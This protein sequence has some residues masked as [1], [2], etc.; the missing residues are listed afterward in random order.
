MPDAEDGAATSRQHGPAHR[1]GH[2]SSAGATTTERDEP[3]RDELDRDEADNYAVLGVARDATP[4]ELRHAYHRL[5]K[6]WHPDRFMAAPPAL[7]ERAER[8]TRALNAAYAVLGDLDRRAAYDLRLP[9]PG[10]PHY[11][12]AH[13]HPTPSPPA[14]SELGVR[15]VYHNGRATTEPA[16]DGSGIFLGALVGVIALVL[17]LT[18]LKQQPI[19]TGG[20]LTLGLGFI[21]AG[22]AFWCATQQNILVRLANQVLA[23]TPPARPGHASSHASSHAPSHAPSGPGHV[24]QP[25]HPHGAESEHAAHEERAGHLP[26]EGHEQHEAP[27]T[28]ASAPAAAPPAAIDPDD[29]DDAAFEQLVA[30][31]L[32]SIPDQFKTY[33][34]NVAVR[35]KRSPSAQEIARLSLREHGLLLGLYEGVDVTRQGAAGAPQPEVITI[36]RRPI[37][38]YCR[39][40]PDRIREQV[41]RTVLHE[42]AH[43]FGI[44]HDAMPDW[45]R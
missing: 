11:P 43:H 12:P 29:E 8:R 10:A 30:E 23:G 6:L 24:H 27:H 13:S 7:R 36:Y 16:D 15:D 28:P 41:R 38:R 4:D 14:P 35:V 40:D 17:I 19:G 20:Y 2:D 1:T 31:A 39:G 45:I 3:D 32:E 18:A 44:D 21:L 37:E 34:N 33:L 9:P 22:V 26:H 25:H 5:A 42:L